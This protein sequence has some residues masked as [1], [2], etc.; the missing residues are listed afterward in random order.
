MKFGQFMPYYKIK[1]NIKKFYKACNPNTSSTP[2]LCLQRI[3]HN[4]YWK[5]KFLKEAAYIRYVLAK[6]SIFVQIST[7]IPF[8][9]GFL[10]N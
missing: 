8:D 1:K 4:I 2:F 9:R 5:M 6:L 3:M 7:L 10:E